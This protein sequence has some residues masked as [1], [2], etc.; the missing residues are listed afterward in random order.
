MFKLISQSGQK[1]YG[2]EEWIAE[3]I[4]EMVNNERIQYAKPG[5]T[6]MV[7]ETDEKGKATL[8]KYMLYFG[9]K[10]VLIEEQADSTVVTPEGVD[11][12]SIV[13][14]AVEEAMDSKISSEIDS[15]ME[16][17]MSQSYIKKE[18]GAIQSLDEA[19]GNDN[20]ITEN[21]LKAYPIIVQTGGNAESLI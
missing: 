19:D 6:C 10:W 18:D 11:L 14:A 12:E 9:G 7:I 20:L 5:S 2:I 8:K 4:N 16:T 15:K 21:E 3:S 1:A 13:A 17:K